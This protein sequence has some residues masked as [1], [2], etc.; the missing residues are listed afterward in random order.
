MRRRLTRTKRETQLLEIGAKLAENIGLQDVNHR[1]IAVAASVCTATIFSYFASV[2]V[3]REQ[4]AREIE[5]S[6]GRYPMANL[7][8]TLMIARGLLKTS[9]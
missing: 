8:V 4:L 7:E 3:L 5:E 6:P 9:P 1:K 2:D